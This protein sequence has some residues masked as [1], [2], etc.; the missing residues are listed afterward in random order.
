MTKKRLYPE[1]PWIEMWYSERVIRTIK[2]SKGSCGEPEEP[3]EDIIEYTLDHVFI[4]SEEVDFQTK[5]Y[6]LDLG[7]LESD[8]F[9]GLGILIKRRLG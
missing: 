7:D 2:G 9:E 1:E 8:V 4:C 5:K 6:Y 3:D